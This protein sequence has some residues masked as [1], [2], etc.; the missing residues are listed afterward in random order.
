MVTK[1]IVLIGMTGSG[2]TSLGRALAER[3]HRPWVDLDEAVVDYAG[4]SI[5][6]LFAVGEAYFRQKEKE[7]TQQ[8]SRESG[9]VISTGGGVVLDPE[10]MASLSVNGLILYIDRPVEAIRQDIVVDGR[11]LLEEAGRDHLDQMYQDRHPL[12]SQYSDHVLSNQGSFEDLLDQA[13]LL[14]ESEEVE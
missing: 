8:V 7:I 9:L 10:N 6:D 3:L 4:Q 2:K 12:Y 13:I 5:P 14:I 1:N 11:P